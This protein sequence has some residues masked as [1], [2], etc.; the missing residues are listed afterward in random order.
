M[1]QRVVLLWRN[2]QMTLGRSSTG[3][4]LGHKTLC[5]KLVGRVKTFLKTFTHMYRVA[6]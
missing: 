5:G 2:L 1:T 6:R 4:P 3:A